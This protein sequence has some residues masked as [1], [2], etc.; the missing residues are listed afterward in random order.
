MSEPRI[1]PQA[2]RLVRR[3][4]RAGLRGFG[5]FL[6]CLFLG[7]FA[8]S[9]IGSFTESAK[10][11]LLADASALLGGD[12]EAHLAH[13]PLPA[14]T[15]DYLSRR[16]ELSHV[17]TLRTMVADANGDKR[18]L[19]ELKAVD[20]AYPLY[21][22]VD[23]E[24]QQSIRDGLNNSNEFGA[25]VEESLLTRLNVRIGDLVRVGSAEFR[26][27]GVITSEPDRSIRAF[28]L[29]PRFLTSI[30][31]LTATGLLQPGSMV[32]HA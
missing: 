14:E 10:S 23:I 24:P 19:T 13:R 21:G 9:A 4:L 7:V 26:I 31:G 25:L 22:Q 15:I 1:L 6:T 12:F 28:N 30:T 27:H 32:Y 8:I 11:G 18:L 3:E 2:L 29:G 5:V 17:M 20:D 16:G